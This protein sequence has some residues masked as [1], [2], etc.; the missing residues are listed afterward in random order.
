MELF[1]F[2]FQNI[3]SYFIEIQLTLCID[4]YT[5]VSLNLFIS[6]NSVC[7]CVCVCA[8]LAVLSE[9]AIRLHFLR[10][11]NIPV[12]T[13]A[14]DYSCL[15]PSSPLWQQTSCQVIIYRFEG[16]DECMHRKV[17]EICEQYKTPANLSE[18]VISWLIIIWS[19]MGKILQHF[20]KSKLLN[21][22]ERTSYSFWWYP[23]QCHPLFHT[24]LLSVVS[25][26][27]GNTCP[28]QVSN[29]WP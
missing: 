29:E 5:T 26:C 2:Y 1:Q 10:E 3:D 20:C 21:V 13:I 4:L 16:A 17:C 7:V 18:N 14:R 22:W 25:K 24:F 28:V 12:K 19:L 23:C 9:T 11:N 15:H 27:A 8:C 6:Y